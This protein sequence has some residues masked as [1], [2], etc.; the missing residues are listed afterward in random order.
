MTTVDI[1]GRTAPLDGEERLQEAQRLFRRTL[2]GWASD[3]LLL[4]HRGIVAL[5]LERAARIER[6]A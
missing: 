6:A 4:R 1:P 3:L 5:D 2:A